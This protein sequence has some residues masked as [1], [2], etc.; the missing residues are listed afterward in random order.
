MISILLI[1]VGTVL[2][3]LA[4]S[5]KTCA[6]RPKKAEK[7]EKGEII[8]QL[9]EL[10]EPENKVS[11]LA[12]PTKNLRLASTPA[13]RGDTLQKATFRQRNSKGKFSRPSRTPSVSIRQ[14]QTDAE[15]EKEIRQRAYEL[16]QER[17]GAEGNP[18]DDWLQAKK[19]VLS[20][21]AKAGTTSA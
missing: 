1:G 6:G 19:E 5:A 4:I 10:S 11:P 14:N 17:G 21:K 15:I 13:T 18:T 9:L 3:V 12:P 7:W 8:K 20:H 2:L 16:Y